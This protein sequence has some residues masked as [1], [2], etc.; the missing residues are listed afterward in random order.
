MRGKNGNPE[1]IVNFAQGLKN[2]VLEV[3]KLHQRK[4]LKKN[5]ILR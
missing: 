5:S 4:F 3:L 2:P 1:D